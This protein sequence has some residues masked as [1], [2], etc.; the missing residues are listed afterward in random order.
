MAIWP[1]FA[2]PVLFAVMEPPLL[3]VNWPA[4]IPI[5]PPDALG[6]VPDVEAEIVPP[7]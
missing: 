7:F 6:A 3:R 2:G 5:L 1:A 4:V